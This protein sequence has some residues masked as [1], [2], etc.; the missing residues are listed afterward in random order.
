MEGEGEDWKNAGNDRVVR[1]HQ[2]P[3]GD[4]VF[5]V[6]AANNDGVWNP[7]G[8]SLAISVMPFYWQTWWFRLGSGLLLVGLGGALVWSWSRKRIARA[9]ER[10]RVADE[11]QL[12][13]EELAHSSRVTTMGQLASGL[14]HEL[15]QPLG[16]ILRNAEAAEM[17]MEQEPPDLAEI[18][19]I[20]TDIRQDDQRAAGVINRMRALLK[21]RNVERARLSSWELLHEVEALVRASAHQRKVQL[22]LDVSPSLPEICGDRVQLQ[23]VL[24][25]LLL[26]G[27]DAMSQEPSGNRRLLVQARQ[28]EGQMIEISVRDSGPGIP[29]QS[30]VQVFEPF[31][32][33]KPHGMGM[34]LAVSKTIVEAHKGRIWAENAAEGGARFCFTVPMAEGEGRGAREGAAQ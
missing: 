29:A 24:L 6:R 34:G 11:T 19:A 9:V 2:L 25:N 1:F 16:A 22:T 4:Y 13:R 32:T 15:G 30:L 12:L 26:N 21:R 14:A 28:A 18:R 5:R 17:L 3:A 20:L 10:E 23:Q 8:A 31:F 7:T 27:M 33:T